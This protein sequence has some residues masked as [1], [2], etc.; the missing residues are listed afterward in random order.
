MHKSL[1]II[2][3]TL[4]GLSSCAVVRQDEVGVKRRFGRISSTA[5][6]P[7]MVGYNPFTTTVIKI[8]AR[9]INREIRIDLPSKEGLTIDSE[10][11]ILYRIDPQKAPEILTNTGLRFGNDLILPVFRSAA[12]DITSRFFAKDLHSGERDQIEKAIRQRMMDELSGRGF[13]IEAVLMK[14]IKLPN[15][16]SR[17]IEDKLQAEQEAQRMQFVLQRERLEA[18]RKKIEAE[19]E[20]DA[21]RIIG[22]GLSP[23]II[24]FRAIEAFKTLSRSPNTKIIITDGKSPLLIQPEN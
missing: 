5:I 21:Q 12:A 11:S 1:V 19:G 22:E 10:I 13:I 14:S 9:T 17:A 6:M 24:N 20:R 8:P 4:L 2:L 3:V 18:D 15:G 7:G 23:L 16:L